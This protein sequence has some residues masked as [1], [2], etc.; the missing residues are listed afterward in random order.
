M[1]KKITKKI[2]LLGKVRELDFS[3]PKAFEDEVNAE[4]KEFI[5]SNTPT[6]FTAKITVG[7]DNKKVVKFNWPLSYPGEKSYPDAMP[8]QLGWIITGECENFQPMYGLTVAHFPNCQYLTPYSE[9][10]FYY[11]KN[12]Y[13]YHAS[14][15][16]DMEIKYSAFDGIDMTLTF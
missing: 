6:N 11:K 4:L 16:K 12:A 15:F 13:Y 10:K 8:E 5:R 1:S 7:A 9:F 3:N 14:R 2:W